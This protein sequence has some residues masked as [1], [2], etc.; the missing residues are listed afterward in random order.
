MKK[1]RGLNLGGWLVLEKWM[2]PELYEATNA[3]DEFHLLKE[4]KDPETMLLNHRNSFITEDDFLWI[5]EH[6]I[7]TV[8]IP[9]GHWLFEANEPYFQ[10]KEYL[11]KAFVWAKKH[12]LDVVLDVHAAKGCQNGFDNGGLSGVI[13]WHKDT[14]NIDETLD[15]ISKLCDNYGKAKSLVGIELLNEPHRTIDMKIIQDFYL[16]GYKIIRDK[17]G[18]EIFVIFHDAFRIDKWKNFFTDNQFINVY[19]DTHMYQVFG[20]VSK[21]A[22]I[23]ELI[24]FVIEKRMKVIREIKKLVPIIIGEW[25]VGISHVTLSYANN[26]LQKE[27]YHHVL[28]NILLLA[29]EEA[30]GWFFWNYKLSDQSTEKNPGWS[31]KKMVELGF[32]P[33]KKRGS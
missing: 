33:F 30:D 11:D 10:A 32:L 18:R 9:V 14:K 29:F 13:D 25:S 6:G 2:T 8:R 20:E 4:I 17:L 24:N 12:E 22:N 1:I 3:E 16:R 23:F 19:L 15:F 27:A 31:F 26:I 5:K 28:A 7:D 21:E